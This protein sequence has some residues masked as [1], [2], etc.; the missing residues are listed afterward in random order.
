M[1]TDARRIQRIE[2]RIAVLRATYAA[3]WPEP[4]GES[5]SRLTHEDWQE[6]KAIRFAVW[7]YEQDR[8][9]LTAR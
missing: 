7:S 5:I 3:I 1:N 8:E 6:L 2:K 4:K 9:R